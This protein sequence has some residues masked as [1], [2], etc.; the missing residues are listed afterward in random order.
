MLESSMTILQNAP[1]QQV[2]FLLTTVSQVASPVF[3]PTPNTF[4]PAVLWRGIVARPGEGL[5]AVAAD[6]R[7]GARRRPG[8]PLAID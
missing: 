3:S 7:A 8:G 4:K 6:G 2:V 5:L 1:I